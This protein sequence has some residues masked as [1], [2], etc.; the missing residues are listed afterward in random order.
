[1]IIF[2]LSLVS[3]DCL[4]ISWAGRKPSGTHNVA[5]PKHTSG[6]ERQKDSISSMK[7]GGEFDWPNAKA[8]FWFLKTEEQQFYEESYRLNTYANQTDVPAQ[9]HFSLHNENTYF[10]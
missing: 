5:A 7:R 4:E 10:E 1:M 9:S 2:S 6:S 8:H 3:F